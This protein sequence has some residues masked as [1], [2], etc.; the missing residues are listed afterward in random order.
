MSILDVIL[1]MSNAAAG[2]GQNTEASP[3]D[4]I[5]QLLFSAG[6]QDG[7][8]LSGLVGHLFENSSDSQKQGLLNQVMSILGPEGSSMA[9]ETLGTS[10]SEGSS[11]YTEEHAANISTEQVQAFI[12]QAHAFAPDLADRIGGFYSEHHDLLHTV[13]SFAMNFLQKSKHNPNS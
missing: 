9:A 8:D 3:V 4:T 1:G 5:K 13:G 2:A 7:Q 10:P 6:T 11:H 12:A